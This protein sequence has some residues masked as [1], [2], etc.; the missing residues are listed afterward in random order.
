[1]TLTGHTRRTP[2][3]DFAPRAAAPHRFGRCHRCCIGR[4]DHRRIGHRRQRRRYDDGSVNGDFMLTNVPA[5]DSLIFQHLNYT[6]LVVPANG[7]TKIDAKLSVSS[8]EI[9]EVVAVGYG[10][11]RAATSPARSR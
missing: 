4:T 2:A 10:Y 6:R 9:E 11:V 3:D 1:M 5:K 8:V 7:R